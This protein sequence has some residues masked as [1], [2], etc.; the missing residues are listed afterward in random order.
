M[1]VVFL[2][3]VFLLQAVKWQF[4]STSV[5]NIMSLFHPVRNVLYV[6]IS[7]FIIECSGSPSLSPA[8]R[9][10]QIKKIPSRPFLTFT[11]MRRT[12]ALT[13]TVDP[14]IDSVHPGVNLKIASSLPLECVCVHSGNTQL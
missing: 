13:S 3:L 7:M 10:S 5:R 4:L 9:V 14:K 11:T 2:M 12:D 6:K 8:G 1:A